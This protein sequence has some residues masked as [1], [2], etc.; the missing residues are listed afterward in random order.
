[1]LSV[2]MATFDRKDRAMACQIRGRRYA[3]SSTFADRKDAASEGS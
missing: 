3:L 1:M 2:R